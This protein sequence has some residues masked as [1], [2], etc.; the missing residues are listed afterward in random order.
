MECCSYI[1]HICYVL[2][3]IP[4]AVHGV[5][6]CI[7]LCLLAVTLP[8]VYCSAHWIL[9]LELWVYGQ[10]PVVCK[11]NDIIIISRIPRII[12]YFIHCMQVHLFQTI[13][14]I[15]C[16]STS[17]TMFCTFRLVCTIYVKPGY[18]IYCPIAR[19]HM[20]SN[21]HDS[22]VHA[23]LPATAPLFSA[24]CAL[25]ASPVEN[26]RTPARL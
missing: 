17:C 11:Q 3:V 9:F 10:L 18:Y 12:D 26:R 1:L 25:A 5:K 13:S 22:P 20:Q 7:P 24:A 21:M 16:F 4:P 14:L 19:L 23:V 6:R 15:T 8:I 2:H